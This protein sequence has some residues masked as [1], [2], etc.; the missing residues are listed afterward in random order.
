MANKTL[1]NVDFSYV[2]HP[3]TRGLT[4][5]TPV[6]PNIAELSYTGTP[7]D[8]EWVQNNSLPSVLAPKYVN[9]TDQSGT[10]HQLT[11]GMRVIAT[12]GAWF[13]IT[14]VS[15][16]SLPQVTSNTSRNGQVEIIFS[17]GCGLITNTQDSTN[18]IWVL[19][20][21]GN[22]QD[23]ATIEVTCNTPPGGSGV[24]IRQPAGASFSLGV[25]ESARFYAGQWTRV[26]KGGG[27][28]LPVKHMTC[29]NVEV[30]YSSGCN[31]M[32]QPQAFVTDVQ[33]HDL[34]SV[35][36]ATIR[37]VSTPAQGAGATIYLRY[38]VAPYQW[39]CIGPGEETVFDVARGWLKTAPVFSTSLFGNL[40]ISSC[41]KCQLSC[42]FAM[43]DK[44]LLEVVESGSKAGAVIKNE[45]T[46]S[47]T[48][49]IFIW[50]DSGRS[51]LKCIVSSGQEATFDGSVW[52]ARTS[53]KAIGGPNTIN[54]SI[55]QKMGIGATWIPLI[56]NQTSQRWNI[57]SVERHPISNARAKK[58]TCGTQGRGLCST[59][60]DLVRTD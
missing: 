34:G 7:F 36:G 44:D 53:T 21:K 4:W 25:G 11:S 57:D 46:G 2:D 1:G 15:A 52:V 18:S 26:S 16:S 35:A 19:E 45:S 8:G 38:G 32:T 40:A 37:N 43:A 10:K 30:E 31:F 48:T 59:W 20:E 13:V 28:P 58:C 56:Y 47:P 27:V 5:I 42:S 55:T 29:G 14:A 3:L 33:L 6:N 23:T 39:I 22:S 12:N 54:G 17:S 50:A 49:Q 9:F 24:I 41:D 51:V 60:C